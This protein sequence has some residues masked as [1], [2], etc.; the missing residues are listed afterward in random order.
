MFIKSR[1]VISRFCSIHFIVILA[2]LKKIIRYTE[3]SLVKGR[4]RKRY[5]AP[6]GINRSHGVSF[7]L[8][9]PGEVHPQKTHLNKV[10][11]QKKVFLKLSSLLLESF[12][13]DALG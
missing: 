9:L 13:V 4:L 5:Y 6:P 7:A 3:D 10:G 1:L 11:S 12:S 8:I 2:G